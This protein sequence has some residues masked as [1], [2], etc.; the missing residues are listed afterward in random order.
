L[1]TQKRKGA[2]NIKQYILVKQTWALPFGAFI[3]TIIA[4]AGFFG[5]EL[6]VWV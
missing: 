5:K 2:S 3:L 6:E 1:L 4:V